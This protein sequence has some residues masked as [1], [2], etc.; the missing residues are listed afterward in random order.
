MGEVKRVAPGCD[1]PLVEL[2]G[3]RRSAGTGEQHPTCLLFFIERAG[4][5]EEI[6][7]GTR[8]LEIVL[9]ELLSIIV[10]DLHIRSERQEIPHPTTDS[11]GHK[12]WV[13]GLLHLALLRSERSSQGRIDQFLETHIVLRNEVDLHAPGLLHRPQAL[14]QSFWWDVD[15]PDAAVAHRFKPRQH[16][17]SDDVPFRLGQAHRYR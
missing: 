12:G 6:W 9:R 15:S 7:P 16:L 5:G 13:D 2:R 14:H 11:Y 17:L 8:R 10:G 1:N 4:H 3:C